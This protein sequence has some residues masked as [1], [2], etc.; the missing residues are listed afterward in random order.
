MII[1]DK[2]AIIPAFLTLAFIIRA[3]I[4]PIYLDYAATTPVDPR[5]ATKMAQ[6]LMLD[7]NFGNPASV[8]V[9]GLVAKAAVDTARAQVADLIQANPQEIVWTSGATEANNLALKGA[10]MLYQA[11]GK[12]I[13]TVKTEHPS[14][15]DTCQQLEKQGYAVTYLTPSS[16]GLVDIAHL[17]S[18]L[19]ADTMLVSVM[20]VNNETGVIQ[21]IK[22]I[23][24]ITASRGILLHVDAAQSVGKIPLDVCS[25]PVDLI[26][27]SAH[28]IYGPKGIG[29]LYVR[30][31]PRV[32]V[33]AQIHGG[34]HESGM[35]SGTLATHQIVGMGAAF[36]IAKQ[37]MQLDEQKIR[38]LRDLFLQS[39]SD[40]H[41]VAINGD[42][43]RSYPGILNIRFPGVKAQAL[44]QALPDL[45]L[46][47][48]SACL[49]KGIEP[50][51]VLRSMGQTAEQA[52][53]GIRV[54]FGRFTKEVEI[55]Q[56][57][58][59]IEQSLAR[60]ESSF[61]TL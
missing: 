45:A 3:M 23:S 59:Q 53:G 17:E 30:R 9:F 15:L 52:H 2:D 61:S 11:K 39:I 43:S 26:S 33:A 57:I 14:V 28:K 25:M 50:S 20:H 54:S 24:D 12:H 38:L 22:A 7:G 34:G 37:E 35:R 51:Y 60:V 19:R 40:T 10:A 27:L 13:V 29:A 46:S 41:T 48:G 4:Q 44:L 31:K 16:N 18:V 21:N 32:R 55:N 5:V 49:S 47:V 36:Q 42:L 58:A 6:Y 1:H 56:A 8:H